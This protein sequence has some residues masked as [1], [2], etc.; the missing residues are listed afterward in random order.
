MKVAKLTFFAHISNAQPT[1]RKMLLF[2]EK[3]VPYNAA[4]ITLSTGI[5]NEN[6]RGAATSAGYFYL[7]ET[8]EQ[9]TNFVTL[10]K[11][12]SPLLPSGLPPATTNQAGQKRARDV[13]PF[14]AD[15]FR[16]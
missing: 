11:P 6:M 9:F 13:D 10:A 2:A 14:D 3:F 7:N 16:L 4:Y 1:N 5:F 8:G 15:S 12:L